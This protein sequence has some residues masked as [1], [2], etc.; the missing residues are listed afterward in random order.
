MPKNMNLFTYKIQKQIPKLSDI[1]IFNAFISVETNIEIFFSFWAFILNAAV[2]FL[3][4]GLSFD[5]S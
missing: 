4:Y 1:K 2:F 3:V 5:S